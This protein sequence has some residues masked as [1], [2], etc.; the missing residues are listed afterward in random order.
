MKVNKKQLVVALG[1]SLALGALPSCGSSELDNYPWNYPREKSDDKDVGIDDTNG[2]GAKDPVALAQEMKGA[3]N[4]V[5]TTQVHNYQYQRANSVD[6]YAGYWTVTQNKFLYG[7]ALPT[8]YTFPND[9]LMGPMIPVGSFCKATRNAY[10]HGEELGVPH[11]R[12]IAMI[13]FDFIAQE[14]SDIYGPI[15]FDD[16]RAVKRF[17]PFT[18]I[19]QEAVYNRIFSELDEAIEVLKKTQPT[20]SQLAQIEGD[21]GGVSRG[22]WR[23]WVK[24]ANSL[25]LRMAMNIV[26]VDPSLAKQQGE[27]A[28][29]DELGVFTD[30]D[31]FDFTQDPVYC[32]W[33]GN[34]PIWQ[35]SV[36]WDDLRLG[37]SL[38]NIMKRL[39][40]PL[41]G[42]WFSP[43]GN[44]LDKSNVSTG[45][46]IEDEGY[47]GVRQG[48]AMIN[49]SD[50]AHGYGPYSAASSKM[51]SMP[52]P[53]IKRTEMMFIM[54]EA[55]LRGWAVPDGA[56]VE[57]L[58]ERGIRLSFR[59]NGLSDDLATEYM[60]RTK[61]TDD[62]Y[63][64]P[65]VGNIHDI[66]GRVTIGVAWDE[67]DTDEIKLEKIITQKYIAVFPCGA[68]SWTT[69]R[70]TG[71]PR[72]FPVYINNW[73]GIDGE[74]QL[75]RIPYVE[76][77]NNAQ[78]LATLPALLGGPNEGSTRLWWDVPTEIITDIPGD[79]LAKSKR[80]EPK[81]F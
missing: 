27:K 45:Y 26:K 77:P 29:S 65:Y 41:L 64:D 19:T 7:G 12:A 63:T 78:E 52:L 32:D 46:T 57:E 35:I 56:T 68:P 74:L 47:I 37:A 16:L 80:R 76:N 39:G 25:R 3:M 58:Y 61:A 60:E 9:Y 55:A 53:W 24:F 49:K 13:M 30:R 8:T 71:Y 66:K 42:E 36:G 2:A 20:A 44:I 15:A 33:M 23:N 31:P 21:R 6:V 67:T 17:P 34:N 79:D 1:L 50:K 22:D 40:N 73:R 51:L 75:R 81:N 4:N 18:Y 59:E 48:I 70:R 69:F 10:F 11:F 54:A 14:L 72:L 43:H 5:I 62:N 28:M 38:E